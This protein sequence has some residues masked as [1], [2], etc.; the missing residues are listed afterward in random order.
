MY[1][2]FSRV[3]QCML[4]ADIVPEF[5]IPRHEKLSLVLIEYVKFYIEESFTRI[6]K[7]SIWDTGKCPIL[8]WTLYQ[9]E[10]RLVSSINSVIQIIL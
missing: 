10:Q 9:S 1:T 5:I 2:Q 8:F 3:K 4:Q 6:K 7:C